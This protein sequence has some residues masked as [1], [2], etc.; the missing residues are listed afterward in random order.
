MKNRR[1]DSATSGT[2]PKAWRRRGARWWGLCAF[3]ALVECLSAS[4]TQVWE[5]NSY[6]DFVHGHFQ[7][8]SL[9]RDGSLLL[10]PKMDHQDLAEQ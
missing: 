10:A 8:I 5:M 7:D 4:S 3:L 9:T 6:Q 2:D 1:G